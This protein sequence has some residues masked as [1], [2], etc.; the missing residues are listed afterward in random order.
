MSGGRW[1]VAELLI[2]RAHDAIMT[3]LLRYVP[4]GGTSQIA[5]FIGPTWGPPGSC[6][7]QMGPMNLAI[8]EVIQW[9]Q[10]S[11]SWP[12]GNGPFLCR[13]FAPLEYV[14]MNIISRQ[15]EEFSLIKLVKMNLERKYL[16]GISHST[17]LTNQW[18]MFRWNWRVA[19]MPTFSSPV[20]PMRT[21][22]EL[23][24]SRFSVIFDVSMSSSARKHL[25]LQTGDVGKLMS[26]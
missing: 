22:L 19:M 6:R 14:M 23:D 5:R 8:R 1:W 3:S 10:W 12:L 9:S 7:P 11:S 18:T 24:N 4:A 20:P 2:K 15:Y 26:Y 25:G 17:L 21:K 13:I 16:C